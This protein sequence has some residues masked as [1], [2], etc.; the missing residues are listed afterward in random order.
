MGP[1]SESPA[2]ELAALRNDLHQARAERGAAQRQAAANYAKADDLTRA[3]TAYLDA[4]H[5]VDPEATLGAKRRLRALVGWT[6]PR[7]ILRPRQAGSAA[8][9]GGI[10]GGFG[11]RGEEG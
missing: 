2:D 11:T 9:R 6:P 7:E 1:Y 8:R 3:I 10:G 4:D 5:H